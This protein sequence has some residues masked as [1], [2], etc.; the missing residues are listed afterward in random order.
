MKQELCYKKREE[1]RAYSDADLATDLNDR[2]STT[3]YCFS[4]TESG[5]IISWMFEKQPTVALSAYEAEYMALAANTRESLY[6]SQLLTE[7]YSGGQYTPVKIFEDKQNAIALSK[8][9]LSEM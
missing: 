1:K 6:L 2:Q 4:L 8:K 9:L 5:P 7:M 3:R